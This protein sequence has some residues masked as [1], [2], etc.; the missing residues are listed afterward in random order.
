M[1]N[2]GMLGKNKKGV[3]AR[4]REREGNLEMKDDV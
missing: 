1:K 3:R 4:Q 2:S